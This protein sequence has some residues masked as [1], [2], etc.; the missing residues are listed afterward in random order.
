MRVHTLHPAH[1]LFGRGSSDLH[2]AARTEP[3]RRRPPVDVAET[4]EHYEILADLPGASRETIDVA[5]EEGVLEIR[6]EVAAPPEAAP[7]AS[8][9]EEGEARPVRRVVR[10]ERSS[11]GYARKLAFQDDVDVDAIEAS[12]RDGVLRVRVPKAER[13][14]PRQIPV[15]VH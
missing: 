14:R 9:P 1:R 15:D 4:P 13:L 8:E 7:S 11:S 6:A 12:F 2:R 10:R 5:F 3:A